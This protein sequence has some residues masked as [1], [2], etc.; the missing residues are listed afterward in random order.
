MPRKTDGVLPFPIDLS[1]PSGDPDKRPGNL[2]VVRPEILF[3][4]KF[5]PSETMFPMP[6][7][8]CGPS[9]AALAAAVSASA[10]E[11]QAAALTMKE[12]FQVSIS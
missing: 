1:V 11:R 4:G 7:M 12:A 6:P 8:N 3:G 5:P 9:L 10:G 2:S